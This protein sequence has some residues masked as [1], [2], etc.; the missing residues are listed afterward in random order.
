M[1]RNPVLI[2]LQMC[3]LLRQL[4]GLLFIALQVLIWYRRPLC[5]QTLTTKLLTRKRPHAYC[6]GGYTARDVVKL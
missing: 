1:I 4:H 2:R 3:F 6:T 5:I